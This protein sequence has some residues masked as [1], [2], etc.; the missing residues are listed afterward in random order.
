MLWNL[1]KEQ[2]LSKGQ[3]KN[4]EI[5]IIYE[6]DFGGESLPVLLEYYVLKMAFSMLECPH[7]LR[8]RSRF[9]HGRAA[10]E[11]ALSSESSRSGEYVCTKSQELIHVPKAAHRG[12][13]W[14][15]HR[16]TYHCCAILNIAN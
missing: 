13:P 10:H 5:G 9:L 2:N 4:T 8:S 1:T 15:Y 6:Y 7:H 14:Q 12:C 16:S 11:R 3:C